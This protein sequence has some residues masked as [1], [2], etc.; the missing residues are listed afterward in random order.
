MGTYGRNFDFRQSPLPQHRLGRFVTGD[1][2]IPNGA[3]VIADGDTDANGRRAFILAPSGTARP[4]PGQ[5]GICLYEQ[6]DAV[7]RGFDPGITRP[8]DMIDAP[9]N[10]PAQMCHGTEVRL[11]L[12]NTSEDDFRGMR[13]ASP[14]PARVM[15]AGASGATPT[16]EVDELIGPGVGTDADGYWQVV[17]TE[18]DAWAVVTEVDAEIGLVVAQMLF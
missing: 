6:P 1:S 5:G 9:A 17:A 16:V 8:S 7:Y 4:L 15:V 3:P 13:A 14:Y 18:A 11:A 12:W 2:A 10:T